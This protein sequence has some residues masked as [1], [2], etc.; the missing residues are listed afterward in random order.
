M[1]LTGQAGHT[2]GYDGRGSLTSYDNTQF[3]YDAFNHMTSVAGPGAHASYEYDGDDLR[4]LRSA[5]GATFLYVHD[6]QGRLLSEPRSERSRRPQRRLRVRG[7]AVDREGPAVRAHRATRHPRHP[8]GRQ[9]GLRGTSHHPADR[10]VVYPA[11]SSVQRVEFYRGLENVGSATQAPFTFTLTNVGM[12]TYNFAAKLILADGRMA[13]SSPVPI[14][15]IPVGRPL[16][17]T[18]SPSS[19]FDNDDVTITVD[20]LLPCGAL[21]FDFGDGS[22]Y[23]VDPIGPTYPYVRQTP[24]RWTTPGTYRVKIYGHGDCR[25]SI[26]TDL[27]ITARNPPP[28]ATLT[29]PAD[30]A[31]ILIGT[32]I[33]LSANASDPNGSVARV[34][35]F[36]GTTLIGSD[37]TAPYAITWNNAPGDYRTLKAVAVD[38]Q[39]ATGASAPVTIRVVH[40]TGVTVNPNPVAVNQPATVTVTGSSLC[41]TIRIDYGDGSAVT[42][43]TN[44]AGLPYTT[45]QNPHTWSTGG[46]KTIT[47]TGQG[48]TCYGQVT[49]TLTVNANPPPMVALTAPANGASFAAPASIAL[50][51]TA[52]DSD[53]INRVEFYSG[54]TLIGTDTTS[55][56]G[57]TWSGI[58]G[59]SYSFTAKAYDSLGASATSAA[60]AVTVRHLGAV[61]V[62]P[63]PVMVNQQAS[64]TVTGSAGCQ[65]V[66]IDYSDGTAADL[67]DHQPAHDPDAH[68]DNG[69][70]QDGDGERQRSELQRRWLDFDHRDGQR[71]PAADGLPDESGERRHV[72]GASVNHAERD[73]N[74]QRRRQPGRVLLGQHTHRHGHDLTLRYDVGGNRRRH[75]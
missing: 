24:H 9:R 50:S 22:V 67:S 3:G 4:M 66:T 61:T 64:V 75:L 41:G 70:H 31:N 56:Y 39:G 63:S 8:G 43:T 7:L 30:G 46:T 33:T 32:P 65:A 15:V 71:Q 28:T 58:D 72:R 60:A 48:N 73:G 52:S 53:G 1:R 68:V 69:R 35:F 54:S 16:A 29:A 47:V 74:R 34:D 27:V 13:F 59:G 26:E 40:V 12:G 45:T 49:T 62:S 55:P 19:P 25:S 42:Y 21:G 51:A 11:G 37:A 36:D 2:F 20:V 38:D 23:V 57:M 17:V 18:F 10:D 5:G 6:A 44:G 14:K